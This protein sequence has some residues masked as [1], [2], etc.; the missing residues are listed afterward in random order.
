MNEVPQQKQHPTIA[1]CGIDC[2]LC[3]RHYTVGESRCPGCF[4]PAFNLKHP[5]CGFI[6]CCVKNK[7]LEV[8]GQCAEFPCPRFDR[9][10]AA[11]SFVTHAKSLEHLRTIKRDG[12]SSFLAQQAKRIRLLETIIAD[13]DDGR[14][15]SFFC[16]AATLLPLADL[17]AAVRQAQVTTVNLDRT[18][19]ARLLR[20]YLESFGVHN[21]ISLKLRNKEKPQ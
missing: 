9:W 19:H 13:F 17:D 3:P 10:D 7:R 4:G 18:G 11:D 5:S 14:S 16:M 15:R 2:G 1:C 21:G 6:T 8:C 12:L 20:G